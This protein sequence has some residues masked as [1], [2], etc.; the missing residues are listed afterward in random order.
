MED[1]MNVI[2]QLG[3]PNSIAIAL[4][5]IYFIVQ[6]IGELVELSGKAVPEF[7]KIRKFFQRKKLIRQT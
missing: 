5:V 4:V 2:E 1:L 7:F 3:I 6:V